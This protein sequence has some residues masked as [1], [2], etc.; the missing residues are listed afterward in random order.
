MWKWLE[1]KR[2]PDDHSRPVA[3]QIVKLR[4]PRVLPFGDKFFF[5]FSGQAPPSEL[6]PSERDRVNGTLKEP[7]MP[8]INKLPLFR[9]AGL[10]TCGK[11]RLG[12]DGD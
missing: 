4:V 6:C 8:A 1:R 2:V 7:F 9:P 10:K 12:S 5:D 11:S 3:G